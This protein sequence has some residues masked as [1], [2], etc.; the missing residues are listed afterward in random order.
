MIV[1]FRRLLSLPFN[2]QGIHLCR[3][4]D[5]LALLVVTPPLAAD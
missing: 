1:S 4:I 5:A 3:F 2:A